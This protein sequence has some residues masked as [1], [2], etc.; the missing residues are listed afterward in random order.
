MT[1]ILLSTW[2][3]AGTL[4]FLLTGESGSGKTTFMA[5][6]VSQRAEAL[7]YFIREDSQELL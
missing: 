4:R 2:M 7:R 6:L 3:R 5:W 1:S